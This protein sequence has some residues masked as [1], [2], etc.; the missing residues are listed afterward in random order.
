M[1]A[2]TKP[3][4]FFEAVNFLAGKNIL[5]TQMTT[6]ELRD[7][8]KK[9]RQQSFF[10][11][12][13]FFTDVLAREKDLIES[14]LNPQQEARPDAVTEENPQGL[15][16]VGFNPATA[17]AAIREALVKRGYQAEP[18]KRGGLQDLMSDRRINLVVETNEK[19]AHGYG[20]K[21]RGETRTLLNLSP[22]WEL[23]R[24]EDREKPRNWQE[25]FSTAGAASGREE[26][27]GWI[28]SGERMIALKNHPIWSE[29]GSSSNFDDALDVDYPP[30]AFGSGMWVR[31][32]LRDECLELGILNEGEEVDP[33]EEGFHVVEPLEV[34]P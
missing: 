11:A 33:G 23:Y 7:L 18:G 27:D 26:G 21:R 2:F 17:R 34:E 10:S 24:Q 29:L 16:T 32:V 3:V 4:P 20:F 6:S 5:P 30:F 12:Q 19:L 28:I 31:D 9:F 8:D 14:I 22:G 15:V 1:I 13:N 25:R